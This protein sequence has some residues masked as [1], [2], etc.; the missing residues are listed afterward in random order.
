M[1]ITHIIT[2]LAVGGAEIMLLKLVERLCAEGVESE[3]VSLTDEGPMGHQLRA[4]G[5]PVFALGMRR[6]MP[7]PIKL[8]QLAM[9]SMKLL[10]KQFIKVPNY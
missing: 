3:V 10:T 8:L 6:G 9:T 4:L 7:S 5:V 2:D 1:K